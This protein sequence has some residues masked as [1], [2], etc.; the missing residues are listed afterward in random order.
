MTW[1]QS[2]QQQKYL[3]DSFV[4]TQKFVFQ[5]DSSHVTLD[6]ILEIISSRIEQDPSA[7][8]LVDFI[9]NLKYML[10]AQFLQENCCDALEKFEKKVGRNET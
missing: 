9:P 4:A 3:L 6:W 10:K 2:H 1:F 7:K 5:A 8:Y